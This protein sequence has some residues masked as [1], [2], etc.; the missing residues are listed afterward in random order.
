MS[1]LIL[2]SEESILISKHLIFRIAFNLSLSWKFSKPD[3]EKKKTFILDKYFF[4]SF[5]II[6][7]FVNARNLVVNINHFGH[8]TG[9]KLSQQILIRLQIYWFLF[10]ISH[11]LTPDRFWERRRMKEGNL[12]LRKTEK[13]AVMA[14]LNHVLLFYW[15]KMNEFF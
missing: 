11:S 10:A 15:E 4:F 3:I 7:L 9:T 14:F 2:F 5:N 13:N 12:L 1:C 6:S 8:Y